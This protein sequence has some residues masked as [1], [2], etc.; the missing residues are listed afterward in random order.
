MVAIESSKLFSRLPA[1]ALRQLRAAAIEKNL[2]DSDVIFEEGDPGDGLYMV[3]SGIVEISV[4]VPNGQRQV[5]SALTPGEIFGEMA[6]VDEQPRSAC[7]SARGDTT[8][9]FVPRGPFS[10]AWS[11]SFSWLGSKLKAKGFVPSN[12]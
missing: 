6:V 8:V 12:G 11:V 10:V 1:A 2:K 3:K 4:E 5:L 7:A 9:Y